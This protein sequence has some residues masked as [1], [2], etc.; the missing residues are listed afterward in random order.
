MRRTDLRQVSAP[1]KSARREPTRK[2]RERAGAGASL[3]EPAWQEITPPRENE[4]E[5]T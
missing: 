1:L 5:V 2:A 3:H 4:H